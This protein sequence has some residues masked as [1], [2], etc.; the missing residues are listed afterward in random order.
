MSC[1]TTR[2]SKQKLSRRHSAL[3]GAFGSAMLA[4]RGR[5]LLAASAAVL[6]GL[7]LALV[8]LQAT[9]ARPTPSQLS[10]D[11]IEGSIDRTEDALLLS[12]P[13]G[14]ALPRDAIEDDGWYQPQPRALGPETPCEGRVVIKVDP[15]DPLPAA[16]YISD[17]PGGSFLRASHTCTDAL[18]WW[19]V[20]ILFL[21]DTRVCGG[22]FFFFFFF[23]FF[24]GL[25]SPP[26][27]FRLMIGG[28]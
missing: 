20:R 8:T 19:W 16:G 21:G 10:H 18:W 25:V 14:G 5:S 1:R 26:H 24:C 6:L 27:D 12:A 4:R 11:I 13:A 22:G 23:F 9:H 3:P 2:T 28:V 7:S 15:S 17:G